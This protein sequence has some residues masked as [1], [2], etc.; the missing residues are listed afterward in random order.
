[1]KFKNI[2]ILFLISTLLVSCAGSNYRPIVDT[3]GVNLEKYE[4]DLAQC[5]EYA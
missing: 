2:L 5:Q 1:M 4:T 3:K